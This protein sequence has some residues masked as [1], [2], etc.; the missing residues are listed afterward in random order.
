V[1]RVLHSGLYYKTSRAPRWASK[2]AK[3]LTYC[4]THQ[5]C[6]VHKWQQISPLTHLTHK[7]VVSSH[8]GSCLTL[9]QKQSYCRDFPPH[10]IPWQTRPPRKCNK[11]I[12]D[13]ILR[14]RDWRVAFNVLTEH[15]RHLLFSLISKK[16]WLL[17]KNEVLICLSLILPIFSPSFF[18]LFLHF[19]LFLVLHFSYLLFRNH[20]TGGL[21]CLLLILIN[22]SLLLQFLAIAPLSTIIELDLYTIGFCLPVALTLDSPFPHL[23]PSLSP[24]L[25]PLF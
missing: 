9:L 15:R 23:S 7:C 5:C 11:R 14:T 3:S 2:L 4:P 1:V 16:Y 12:T 18:I 6:H 17:T 22:F 25:P 19:F 10:V 8:T 20:S 13:K 21:V 24:P